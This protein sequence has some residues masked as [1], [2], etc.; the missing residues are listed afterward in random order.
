MN[1]NDPIRGI[2]CKGCGKP[3]KEYTVKKI[4]DDIDNYCERCLKQKGDNHGNVKRG[5]DGSDN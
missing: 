5:T 4:L 2:K 1:V 3:V